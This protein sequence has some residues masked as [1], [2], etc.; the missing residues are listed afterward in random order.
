MQAQCFVPG[1]VQRGILQRV[2]LLVRNA[3]FGPI[4]DLRVESGRIEEGFPRDTHTFDCF[5][6][7]SNEEDGNSHDAGLPSK[8]CFSRSYQL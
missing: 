4:H 8:R 6:D 2:V 7:R 3:L 5:D 1:Q